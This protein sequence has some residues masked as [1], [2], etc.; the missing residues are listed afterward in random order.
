MFYWNIQ[1]KTFQQAL[2]QIL[3]QIK[4][5]IVIIIITSDISN[6]L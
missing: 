6:K 5:I 1:Q 2:Y 3:D 4:T